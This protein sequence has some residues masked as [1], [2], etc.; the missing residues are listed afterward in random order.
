MMCTI[1]NLKQLLWSSSIGLDMIYLIIQIISIILLPL[2]Y[3]SNP[4]QA[5]ER[6]IHIIKNIKCG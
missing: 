5:F 3:C 4:N 2:H 1:S 6:I